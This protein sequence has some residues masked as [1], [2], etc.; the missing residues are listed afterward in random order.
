MNNNFV[1][2]AAAAVLDVFIQPPNLLPAEAVAES[3]IVKGS[4]SGNQIFP[5]Q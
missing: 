5:Q 1:F 3:F 4:G 2:G